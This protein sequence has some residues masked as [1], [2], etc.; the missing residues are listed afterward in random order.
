MTGRFP[1]AR[2]LV[3]P[4]GC[5]FAHPS[6]EI[7]LFEVAVIPP[8][9]GSRHLIIPRSASRA[10]PSIGAKGVAPSRDWPC[11]KR[12]VC[13]S[14]AQKRL[15][16]VRAG[17]VSPPGPACGLPRCAYTF[18]IRNKEVRILTVPP[19][20]ITMFRCNRDTYVHTGIQKIRKW[21]ETLPSLLQLDFPVGNAAHRNHRE[22]GCGSG[23]R[24]PWQGGRCSVVE[25][26]RGQSWRWGL[27]PRVES[28]SSE[29]FPME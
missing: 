2:M 29:A 17:I 9:P 18:P 21:V 27:A 15:F 25:G 28:R 1:Y 26:G 13:H 5:T 7:Q 16:S 14:A 19:P 24:S 11:R 8:R 12:R 4:P 23:S 22:K 6:C 20:S 3:C 10:A